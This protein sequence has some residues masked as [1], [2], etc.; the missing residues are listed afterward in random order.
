M[1]SLSTRLAYPASLTLCLLSTV[2]MV[3]C[4]G[5]ADPAPAPAPA[6]AARSLQLAWAA[7]QQ[8]ADGS[9]LTDLAGFRILMGT[10]SG[11]YSR[12]ITIDNPQTLSHTIPDLPAATY[13]LVVKAVDSSNNESAPSTE[14]VAT[15]R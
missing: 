11:N 10:S 8:N 12:I 6:P 7:P 5:S 14:L 3:A 15:I 9:A 4:G 13:Y 2:A 1:K